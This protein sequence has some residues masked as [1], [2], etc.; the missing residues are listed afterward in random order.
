MILNKII[1]IQTEVIKLHGLR[2]LVSKQ[3]VNNT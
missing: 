1:F 3:I 2:S